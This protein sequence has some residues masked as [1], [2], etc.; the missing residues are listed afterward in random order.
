M[1][2]IHNL[3]YKYRGAS[4]YALRDIN[5]EIAPGSFVLISGPSGCGK[6]TLALAIGGYLFRQFDGEVAGDINVYGIDVG[7]SSI[8]DVA[9]IV[10]LVQQNPEAQFCTL[11]V[12]DEVAFGLENRCVPRGEILERILAALEMV[13]A[14]HLLHRQLSTLSGGEKQKVAVAAMM[15]MLPQVIIFDEP[16]SNLDPGSTKNL[17]AIIDRIRRESSM[18]VIIIE[19]KVDELRQY[20][21]RHIRMEG[22]QIVHDGNLDNSTAHSKPKPSSPDYPKSIAPLVKIEEMSAGYNGNPVLRNLT[23]NLYAGE[24]VSVMGDNGSGKTTLL[25]CLLGL[26]NPINGRVLVLDQDTRQTPVS[27]LARSVGLVFQNPDHQIFGE[28]VWDEAVFALRNFGMLDAAAEK[29]SSELLERCGLG[30]RLDDH[31]YRLSYGQKRRL[32]LISVLSYQPW[33]VLLDEVLI[34]QDP[35]NAAFILDLVR[36]HVMGGGCTVVVNHA[37]EVMHHYANR[38]IVL[39][40]GNITTTVPFDQDRPNPWHTER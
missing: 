28:S 38:V 35:Q 32:N 15:A 16:T 5:L 13:E 4:D 11:T 22:G 34:G 3:R 40:Q 20:N 1:I 9:E 37:P 36:D 12:Q 29:R 25:Y 18:T 27:E 23:F 8:H 39:D 6:S 24:F 31:P 30:D 17:F 14:G 21:P 33:L 26:L 19:H 2:D 7:K 10:G